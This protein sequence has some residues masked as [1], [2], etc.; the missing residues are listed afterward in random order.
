MDLED[1]YGQDMMCEYELAS[2]RSPSKSLTHH[3]WDPASGKLNHPAYFDRSDIH[4]E[5][6]DEFIEDF[7]V[8][9]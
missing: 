1:V 8:R 5:D 2:G 6:R 3:S 4:L 9:K 7:W